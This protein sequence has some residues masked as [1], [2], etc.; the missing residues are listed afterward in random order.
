VGN[1]DLPIVV[2]GV[3]LPRQ[4]ELFEVVQAD[5]GLGLVPGSVQGRQQQGRQDG[6][7]GNHHQ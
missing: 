6:N 1:S 4:L 3:G 7:A 2:I 5:H